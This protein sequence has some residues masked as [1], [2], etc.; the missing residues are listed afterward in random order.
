[1]SYLAS[2]IGRWLEIPVG[3]NRADMRHGRFDQVTAYR[4]R[5]TGQPIWQADF[6]CVL[7]ERHLE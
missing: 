1:M 6:D 5:A 2:I 4:T 3:A 7:N